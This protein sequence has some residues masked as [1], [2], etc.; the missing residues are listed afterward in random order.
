M[1]E[2]KYIFTPARQVWPA[3][4]VDARLPSVGRLN[5]STWLDQNRAVEQMTWAPGEPTEI[6][7]RLIAEGGWIECKGCSVFN[8]YRAPTIAPIAG[9]ADRWLHHIEKLYGSDAPHII[10]WCAQRV[11][12]PSEKINHALVLGGKQGIG[13]DTALEPVK[14]AVGPWNFLEVSPQ[15]VLGRF[16]GFLKSVI[17]RVSEAR[18]LGD[19][20]RFA[21]YDHMKAFTAAPP[22]V[23]R[24]DEKN[25][26]EYSIPN[27][28]GV[29]ITTNHKTD[30]I[31]LP[32]DDRRH[33][34]AWSDLDKTAFTDKYWKDLWR[35]Y[36]NGGCEVVAHYLQTLDLSAFNAKAPPP[37]TDAFFEIV[38][39]S[40]APEDAELADALDVIGWPAAVTIAS[41][42]AGANQAA[43]IDFLK[44]RKNSR[45]VPHRFEA[46][47][48]TPVRNPDAE[49]GL[50]R[51]N[52]RRQAVYARTI[53]SL[54]DR[55]AAA[56][57]L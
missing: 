1:L 21:F 14:R 33:F 39:A 53:L 18:D 15:Q 20:D 12:K 19:F 29:V 10:R 43:I 34:V 55:I 23:L 31:Y 17:L 30:G 56:Q 22:D 7:D 13:K 37:Q 35:W 52:A 46:C 9:N 57:K 32:A 49:D 5:A 54:R 25:R 47:G 16:N 27:V 38:N 8:L 6:G 24:I 51:I 40:R 42:I 3:S 41:I 4:S 50:W 45:R 48:Y 26:T 36:E 28:C 11:Q 44:D 2:H